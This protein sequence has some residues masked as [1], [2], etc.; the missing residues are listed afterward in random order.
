M[1]S[2]M[3]KSGNSLAIRIPKSYAED[4]GLENKSPVEL[5]VRNGSIVLTPVKKKYDLKEM[6]DMISEENLH[7][8]TD[9]G[10]VVG[11][12]SW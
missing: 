8:E 6:V 2:H 10:N 3:M 9:T 12:E 11:N 4:I 7:R 5:H 1:L